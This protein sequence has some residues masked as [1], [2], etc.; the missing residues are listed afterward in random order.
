MKSFVN[1][2]ADKNQV[3]E[4]RAKA[5]DVEQ[6]YVEDLQQVL[7]TIHGRRFV[8]QLMETCGL[9][10]SSLNPNSQQT[11]AWEGQRSVALSLRAAV[12]EA[13]PEALHSNVSRI[14]SRR[15]DDA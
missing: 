9:H 15:S 4:A 14:A 10:R 13:S 11:Y 1:N 2:A 3:V 8:W 6:Q 5:K 7:S 12:L